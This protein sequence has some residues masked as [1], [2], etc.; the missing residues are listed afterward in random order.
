MEDFEDTVN[1]GA[2]DVAQSEEDESEAEEVNY[3]AEAVKQGWVP[4]DQYKNPD[5]WVD[6]K[7]FIERGEIFRPALNAKY[8]ETEAKY[9]ELERKYQEQEAAIERANKISEK[10]MENY[11]RDTL[12]QLK[13]EQ[14]K[15]WEQGDDARYNELDK[16]RDNLADE[17][18]IEAPKQVPPQ[19]D[20]YVSKFKQEN[21]WYEQDYT[22][23]QAAQFHDARLL[24]ERGYLS[25][26][27]RHAEVK[28]AVIEEF[29]HKFENPNR[30]IKSPLGTGRS[31][32]KTTAKKG[33]DSMPEVDK[34]M[35]MNF[36]SRSGQSKDIYAAA[37]WENEKKEK[38]N[39]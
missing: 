6:A 2:E 22:L 31:P 7:T 33:W 16:R 17:F 39:A 30:Q 21:P 15:A 35:A 20:P 28:R 38:E 24:R 14:K 36:I 10:M 11:K 19:I 1:T 8:K 5:K 27:E 34:K 32:A 26:E 12:E 3:E 37:Y 9:T 29:P 13:T 25:P 4:K 23:T 18:K